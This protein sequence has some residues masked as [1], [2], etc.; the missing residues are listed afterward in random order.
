[1][2]QQCQLP[3]SL[4]QNLNSPLISGSAKSSVLV[5]LSQNSDNLND[6][7][8]FNYTE[9]YESTNVPVYVVPNKVKSKIRKWKSAIFLT[10]F[11]LFVISDYLKS[12]VPQ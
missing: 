11:Y 6:M 4:C 3:C 10:K 5:T 2:Y 9:D 12:H 1:M 8:V 7:T